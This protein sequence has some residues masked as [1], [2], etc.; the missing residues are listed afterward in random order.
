[1]A[2][3]SS[4]IPATN[5]FCVEFLG[6]T[7]SIPFE[8]AANMV[9]ALLTPAKVG[10]RFN[11]D[12]KEYLESTLT[13]IQCD[14]LKPEVQPDA[15]EDSLL[16]AM[17]SNPNPEAQNP[18]LISNA[19]LWL[20]YS[21]DSQ[22]IESLILNWKKKGVGAIVSL[23]SNGVVWDSRNATFGQSQGFHIRRSGA[24]AEN[25]NSGFGFFAAGLVHSLM[26]EL[27]GE[28][29]FDKTSVE[30]DWECVEMRPLHLGQAAESG[31][32]A[33]L[34]SLENNAEDLLNKKGEALRR[35]R[36]QLQLWRGP[37]PQGWG[38]AGR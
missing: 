27:L 2:F 18:E 20:V 25:W 33:S 24:Q 12:P 19:D 34:L 7:D 9:R 31:I 8:Q 26:E 37:E 36:K 29:L 11:P 28:N 3:P 22:N 35:L 4:A 5:S 6:S 16:V 10:V 15:S 21:D 30:L 13:V 14:G 23:H 1:M 17:T 32:T 38:N